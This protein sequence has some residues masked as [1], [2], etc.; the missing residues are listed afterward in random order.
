MQTVLGII[1][2]IIGFYI[3]GVG[4]ALGFQLG[5]MVGGLI[6]GG[7]KNPHTTVEGPRLADLKAPTQ[8][9]GASIPFGYGTIRRGAQV[10]WIKQ[11]KI[12]EQA[13]SVKQGNQTTVTYKYFATFALDCGEGPATAVLRM[14]ANGKL[15]YDNRASSASGSNTTSVAGLSFKFYPGTETQLADPL[16]QAD[17]G[18]ANC[19]A[20]RGHILIVFD[21]LPLEN[22]GNRMPAIEAEISYAQS[23][24]PFNF[25]SYGGGADVVRSNNIQINPY[26]P[27]VYTVDANG[28][29]Y[30]WDTTKGTMVNKTANGVCR[31]GAFPTVDRTGAVYCVNPSQNGINE[32]DA[33]TGVLRGPLVLEAYAGG[34]EQIV[35]FVHP[36]LGRMLSMTNLTADVMLA[37][38]EPV[39]LRVT[40]GSLKTIAAGKVTESNVGVWVPASV[41]GTLGGS[42]LFTNRGNMVVDVRGSLWQIVTRFPQS[43]DPRCQLVKIDPSI[44]VEVDLITGIHLHLGASAVSYDITNF[45]HNANSVIYDP[46]DDGLICSGYSITDDL[47]NV[48]VKVS[49]TDPA[50]L[51]VPAV[52]GAGSPSSAIGYNNYI[53]SGAYMLQSKKFDSSTLQL[54]KDYTSAIGQPTLWDPVGNVAYNTTTHALTATYLDRASGGDELLTDLIA[55]VALR[56]G[57]AA[58]DVD[59]SQLAGKLVHGFSISRP[60]TGQNIIAPLGQAFNFDIGESGFLVTG[61]DGSGIKKNHLRCIDRGRVVGAT[62]SEGPQF[63]TAASSGAG[64]NSV[65]ANPTRMTSE[66]LGD[67][68]T[69]PLKGF[70]TNPLICQN[71]L[72][73]ASGADSLTGLKARVFASCTDATGQSLIQVTLLKRGVV[74]G[75][76]ST[77]KL[78]TVDTPYEF[79]GPG[80]LWNTNWT[81]EDVVDPLTGFQ[82]VAIA[83]NTNTFK[84]RGGKMTLYRGGTEE[85]NIALVEADLGAVDANKTTGED[86]PPPKL[87]VNDEFEYELPSQVEVTY[88]DQD[89]DYNTNTQ[90]SK[91]MYNPIPTMYSRE[92]SKN[93][94]PLAL[95]AA[96]AKQIAELTLW[97][98]FVQRKNY[99][100]S[101]GPKWIKAEAGDVVSAPYRNFKHRIRV[102][103]TELGLNWITQLQGVAS[104]VATYSPSNTDSSAGSGGG[105][106]ETIPAPSVPSFAAFDITNVKDSDVTAVGG[107]YFKIG[108]FTPAFQ[109]GVV[110]G[111]LDRENW[112]QLASGKSL[113]HGA[114]VTLLPDLASNKWWQFDRISTVQVQMVQGSL[115]SALES[116]LLNNSALNAILIGQELIQY[117]T[118]TLV[119]PDTYQLSNLL[120]GL[121]G[122]EFAMPLHVIGDVAI[123][124]EALAHAS[125]PANF[126]DQTVYFRC[127]GFNQIASD[128]AII[129]T[130]LTQEDLQPHAPVH[131]IPSRDGSG[132]LTVT[133]TRRDRTESDWADGSGDA[134]L[135]EGSELYEVDV[136][137]PV[138]GVVLRTVKSLV[139][140][141]LSYTAAQQTTD[142]GSVPSR[143]TLNIFQLSQAIGRGF[144]LSV[145]V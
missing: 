40:D 87:I 138:T 82:V 37:V 38:L 10:V 62:A 80:D 68:T 44:G 143:V 107:V 65:W 142:F 132:N 123:P 113:L 144:P 112:V 76:V 105:S 133:W 22:F 59:T 79:G 56:S 102:L 3:P 127:I 55:D 53:Y 33:I 111:S 141:S 130:V 35:A 70:G 119:A 97:D 13:S 18:A 30:T 99:E 96:E 94:L 5:S 78:T 1:G 61:L 84:V 45:V 72:F 20:Y 9:Y 71:F 51:L 21:K 131:A 85:S 128:A 115:S 77:Q 31:Q 106:G 24:A 108:G 92:V 116:D 86:Q 25:I 11:N 95:K 81:L 89:L 12:I 69:S 104:A 50:L 145:T 52:I 117:A 109:G 26:A 93:E 114:T 64:S 34:L 100:F 125:L 135:S 28:A 60:M 110:E 36:T 120:R 74:V 91:R 122:T 54:I 27:R 129:S 121:R 19:P 46:I 4:P 126:V 63:C 58:D 42:N 136:V 41:R 29:V 75:R 137:N 49:A 39:T 139:T 7:P 43:V 57:Y 47:T 2:G 8:G 73:S 118:A 15:I 23:I 140:P 124:L 17:V 14:W 101:L 16:M 67:A 6:F 48:A 88:G 32:I 98:I 66:G 134:G 83:A 103:R 90:L